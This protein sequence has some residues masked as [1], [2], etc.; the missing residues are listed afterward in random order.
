MILTPFYGFRLSNRKE[1]AAGR[2]ESVNHAICF[3]NHYFD[4]EKYEIFRML[5]KTFDDMFGT[6]G[7]GNISEYASDFL[8]KKYK[9]S[10]VYNAPID[11]IICLKLIEQHSTSAE[12]VKKPRKKKV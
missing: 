7:K 10:K 11:S 3:F 12:K 5:D 2:F 1:I 4:G 6:S 8:K 9:A